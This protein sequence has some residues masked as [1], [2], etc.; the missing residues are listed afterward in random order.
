MDNNKSLTQHISDFFDYCDK[1]KDFSDKTIEN[2][3]RYLDRFISWLKTSNLTHL[4]PSELSTKH[5]NDY[6]IYLSNQNIKKNTQNYYLIALRVLISYFV[7]KEIP[8]SVQIE[9]IKLQKTEKQKP[10]NNLTPE[11]LEKLLSAPNKSHNIGLRDRAI[12]E[13]IC[14]T[15]LKIA[16]L[17]SI[18]KNDIKIDDL[19]KRATINIFDKRGG[20]RLVCVPSTT[21]EWLTKYLDSRKDHDKALFINYRPKKENNKKENY[22]TS[23]EP[24][25]NFGRA[26]V[27]AFSKS[28]KSSIYIEIGTTSLYKLLY[29]LLTVQDST[30]LIIPA[31]EYMIEFKT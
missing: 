11:Q 12:L 30:F 10:K 27:G 21:V 20:A 23:L 1:E 18:N 8:C 17:V 31:E 25:I 14:S 28:S 4:T 5:I 15:G 3:S 9:K 13:I 22:Q 29:N 6:Q 16:E 26:D 7:E 19:T 24:I 2:Y